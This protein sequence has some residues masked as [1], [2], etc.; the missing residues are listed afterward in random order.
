VALGH[1]LASAPASVAIGSSG[2][3]LL[4]WRMAMRYRRRVPARLNFIIGFTDHDDL[5]D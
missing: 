5:F 2:I 1:A 4:V 3:A